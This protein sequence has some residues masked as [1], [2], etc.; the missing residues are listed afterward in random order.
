MD[1]LKG[2][3]VFYLGD[4]EFCADIRDISTTIKVDK[5]ANDYPANKLNQLR[6]MINKTE[7]QIINLHKIFGITLTK[8]D[9]RTRIFMYEQEDVRFGFFVDHVSELISIDRKVAKSLEF[10]PPKNNDLL[11]S[12]IKF[13]GREF[14][15]PDYYKIAN[16]FVVQKS[17]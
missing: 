2:L 3:L 1:N 15:L 9:E 12:I 8:F 11:L 16:R 10:I 6:L 7:V 4:L 5:L 14:Y 17:V 13:E